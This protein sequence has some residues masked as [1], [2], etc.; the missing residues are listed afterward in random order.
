MANDEN[1]YCLAAVVV[2]EGP[3]LFE[4]HNF[5]YVRATRIGDQQQE[6]SGTLSW[7]RASDED[8]TKVSLEEVLKCQAY[9]IFYERV[10]Q[11]KVKTSLET[12]SPTNH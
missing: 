2:H 4:G 9:I 5:A 3:M 1:K 12:H 8:V 6:S 10:E 11:S 7:F